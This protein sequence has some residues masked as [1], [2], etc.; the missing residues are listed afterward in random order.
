MN[1]K[2]KIIIIFQTYFRHITLPLSTPLLA[3]K[4]DWFA[5]APAA[6]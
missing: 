3:L 6:D 4:L 5:E 2:K 1:V